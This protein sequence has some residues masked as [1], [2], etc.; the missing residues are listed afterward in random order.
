MTEP[1]S[2]RYYSAHYLPF[3]GWGA[4]C[5]AEEALGDVEVGAQHFADGKIDLRAPAGNFKKCLSGDA[6]NPAIIQSGGFNLRPF[7]GENS[8]QAQDLPFAGNTQTRDSCR[9][10]DGNLYRPVLNQNQ[11]PRDNR[12]ADELSASRDSSFLLVT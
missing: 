8:A 6:E 2:G 4:R 7:T 10:G 1:G 3:P 11:M 9:S 5:F 12:L